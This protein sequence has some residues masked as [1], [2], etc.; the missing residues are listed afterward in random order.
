MLKVL[1]LSPLPEGLVRMLFAEQL[2]KHKME[3]NFVAIAEPDVELLKK[4]LADA[5]VVIGDFTFKIPITA[6]MVE[7]MGKVKLVAQPSTGYDHIDLEACRKKGIPVC[8]IGGANAISVAEHTMALALMLLKRINYA[9]QRMLEGVWVQ[10]ELLNVASEVHGKTWGIIGLGRIG[11][12]VAARAKAMGASVAYTDLAR[13][14]PTEEQKIGVRFLPLPKL[15]AESDVVS[16][17]VPLNEK[18]RKMI[19]EREL[20]LMKSY[21]VFVNVSRGELVEEEVLAK[22]V[23][24]GWIGGAGVDVFSREPAAPDHPLVA[25][26]RQGT[27]VVL[28][29]HIAGATNDARMRIIQVTVENVM[30]V[31][32][33]QPP[34]NVVNP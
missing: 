23:A 31:L 12:E 4:E 8:N 5:D 7:S 20:R 14:E 25:A 3:A 10:E 34:T 26:A 6:E 22:A 32:L 30:R 18:T 1:V 2:E 27:N 11:R 19:G 24:E 15:L 9:H 33:G 17:H 21:A 28:T 29:P 16:I 13:L